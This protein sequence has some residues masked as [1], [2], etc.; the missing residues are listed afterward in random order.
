MADPVSDI[1]GDYRAF[2][3]QQRD[4][5]AARGRPEPAAAL[6]DATPPVA[7][8]LVLHTRRWTP[9][10]HPAAATTTSARKPP[11]KA[12]GRVTAPP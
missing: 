12:A 10:S 4:R 2:T 8:L 1:I 5:L 7:G 6:S 9:R 3:A 11:I